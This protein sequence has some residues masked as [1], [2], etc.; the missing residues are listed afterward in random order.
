MP[1]P[2]RINASMPVAAE[3]DF[4]GANP[5]A[6]AVNPVEASFVTG[7]SGVV[8]GRFAWADANG[9]VLNSG[10][11]APTGFVHRHQTGLI[12]TF[13]AENGSTIQQGQPVDLMSRGGFWVKTATAATVG[14]KI[15]ANNTDGT[16]STGAAGATVSGSTETIWYVASPGGAGEAIKMTTWSNK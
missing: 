14:Q 7:T 8:I 16:I 12:V 2:S 1:F 15:F 5:Y 4:I 3:G 11:G 13:L 6:S 10:S 9:I